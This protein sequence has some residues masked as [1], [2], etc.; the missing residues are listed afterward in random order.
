MSEGPWHA[1]RRSRWQL[2]HVGLQ[3]VAESAPDD[4]GDLANRRFFY[5]ETVTSQDGLFRELVRA[6]VAKPPLVSEP[7]AKTPWLA[8]L[9]ADSIF[10][11]DLYAE[12]V[13]HHGAGERAAALRRNTEATV[14]LAASLKPEGVVLI[15][16][17]VLELLN[18]PMRDAG[19]PVLHNDFVPFPGSGPQRRL[20]QLFAQAL[21]V[22][23]GFA[24][25]WRRR[26]RTESVSSTP[27][28]DASVTSAD[29]RD[30]DAVSFR[31]NIGMLYGIRLSK[32]P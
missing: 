13:K 15:K 4:G 31:D 12:P 6:L 26:H 3:L 25:M 10:L 9:K 16:R 5:D 14:T 11:M 22:F 32:E 29:A 2:E 30:G 23:D 28:S 1:E 24:T 7:G 19:L 27:S 8:K 17:N 18:T 21:S 20:R